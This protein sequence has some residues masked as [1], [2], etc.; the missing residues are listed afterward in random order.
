MDFFSK[1]VVER[2]AT[3]T[4]QSIKEQGWMNVNPVFI[5]FG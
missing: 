4:R 3:G 2:T 5:F 1:T